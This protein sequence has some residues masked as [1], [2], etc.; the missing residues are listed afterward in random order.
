MAMTSLRRRS[1]LAAMTLAAVAG[2]AAAEGV[3]EVYF[4]GES[5]KPRRPSVEGNWLSPAEPSPG[6]GK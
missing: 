5:K 6:A 3:R 4:S 2:G 1:T